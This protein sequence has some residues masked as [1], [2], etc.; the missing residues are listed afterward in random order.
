MTEQN[1]QPAHFGVN[2][3]QLPASYHQNDEIDLKELFVALWNGKVTIIVT[4]VLFAVVAVAYALT[5]QQWWSSKAKVTEPQLQDMSAYQQQVKQF[6]PVFDIYQ[7]NGTVLVSHELNEF[8]NTKVLFKRFIDAFNSSDN[9]RHFLGSSKE[10]QQ[11]KA[12]LGLSEG[13]SEEEAQ[14]DVR[15]LYSD[16]FQKISAVAE[17]KKDSSSPYNLNFQS[18]TKKSSYS[19]MNEYLQVVGVIAREEALNNL[20]AA[21]DAK[22]NELVQQKRILESQAKGRIEVESKRT[23]YALYIAKAASVDTPIQSYN[24]KEIF[25]IDLG[26]KG[27]AAKAKALESIDNLSVIEP[28]L[29]QIDAK[30]AMLKDL[31]IDRNI[32]F[33]TFRFLENVEQPISRDKPKRPLIAVLGTLLGGMLGVAIVLIRF[34]FRKE[35]D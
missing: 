10:F 3:P 13:Q 19:L 25:S 27:L 24:D 22:H 20:Q 32:Q 31:K 21:V 4:T 23:Q 1:Q 14:D 30:L 18:T 2:P 26:T 15:R 7:E 8:V 17:D 5:A 33:Q 29:Q 12:E 11:Y 34:A 28:R 6:Q 16:W 35:E 9:K